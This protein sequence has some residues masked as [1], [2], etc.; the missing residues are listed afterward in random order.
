MKQETD[1]DTGEKWIVLTGEE[2]QMGFLAQCIEAVAQA[3]GS[4][5]VDMFRRM[6]SADLTRGY[7]LRFYDTLHTESIENITNTLLDLLHR[8]EERLRK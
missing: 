1:K 7:I 6:E 8:R 4:D 3:D 5:Y 2:N